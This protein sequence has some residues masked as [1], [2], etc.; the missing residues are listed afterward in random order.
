MKSK[1]NNSMRLLVPE[2]ES[3]EDKNNDE[4]ESNIST[5]P[6]TEAIVRWGG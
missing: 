6:E 2:V 1:H 3:E 4:R 5:A